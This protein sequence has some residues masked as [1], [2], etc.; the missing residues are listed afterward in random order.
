M[1]A[2]KNSI[3]IDFGRKLKAA[4]KAK[5]V[6]QSDVAEYVGLS[7]TSITNIE[8]GRQQVSLHVFLSLSNAVGIDP[9]QL[10]P[11][12]DSIMLADEKFK[13]VVKDQKLST[14]EEIAV[15]RSITKFKE[16]EI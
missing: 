16:D 11:D 7:R 2:D 9:K 3:Y 8:H 6:T 1:G 4:R 12:M 13:K 15:M 5:R 14:H 10:L